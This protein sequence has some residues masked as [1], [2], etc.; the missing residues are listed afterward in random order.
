VKSAGK[1]GN[2]SPEPDESRVQAASLN[3]EI[4]VIVV[5]RIVSRKLE[6]KADTIGMV[7]GNS[8]CCTMASNM[9]TTGVRERGM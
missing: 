9:D 3:P 2:G 6:T 8:P 1:P 4:F 5:P 7:E